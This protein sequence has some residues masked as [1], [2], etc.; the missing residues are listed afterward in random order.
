[1]IGATMEWTHLEVID[2]AS[3][4]IERIDLS[5]DRNAAVSVAHA[6]DVLGMP[7]DEAWDVLNSG[8]QIATPGFVRRLA[9]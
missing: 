6:A 8:G 1:M 9:K 7:R 4:E 3:G 5:G 2:R